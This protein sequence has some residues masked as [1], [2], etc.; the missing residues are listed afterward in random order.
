[1]CGVI[2]ICSPNQVTRDFALPTSAAVAHLAQLV[3]ADKASRN[4]PVAAVAAAGAD[5]TLSSDWD[6][7][8]LNPFLSLAN[9]IDR[10]Q[11]SVKD[12]KV[13]C[14]K[15]DYFPDLLFQIPL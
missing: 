2:G 9:A 8:D 3:G 14:A 5:V 1:M 4:M 11:Q 6:V 15:R 7:A 10:G 12:I 13:T